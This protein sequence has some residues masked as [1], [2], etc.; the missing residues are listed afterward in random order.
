[1]TSLDIFVA[2]E[3]SKLTGKSAIKKKIFGGTSYIF[4]LLHK[5]EKKIKQKKFK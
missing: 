2:K 3:K 5:N 1:M 4:F